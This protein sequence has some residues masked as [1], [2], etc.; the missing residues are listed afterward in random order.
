MPPDYHVAYIFPLDAYPDIE[1]VR[2]VATS[3]NAS[4]LINIDVVRTQRTIF[5]FKFPNFVEPTDKRVKDLDEFM[6]HYKPLKKLKMTDIDW[7]AAMKSLG[8]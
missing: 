2:R 3:V 1:L 5:A 8:M 4:L 7:F 6:A